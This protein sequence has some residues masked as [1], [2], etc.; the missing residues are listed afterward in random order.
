MEK[1]Q[2]I[3][4]IQRKVDSTPKVLVS[5]LTREDVMK[6]DVVDVSP[7]RTAVTS[8]LLRDHLPGTFIPCYGDED[9]CVGEGTVNLLRNEH[10]FGNELAHAKGFSLERARAWAAEQVHTST[11]SRPCTSRYDPNARMSGMRA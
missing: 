5:P 11:K 1:K 10:H 7:Q 2:L 3:G 4:A 9:S 6:R 8:A